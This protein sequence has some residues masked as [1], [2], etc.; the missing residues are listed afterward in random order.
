MILSTLGDAVAAGNAVLKCTNALRT[1]HHYCSTWAKAAGRYSQTKRDE[2]VVE[3]LH[4]IQVAD[5]YRWLEDPDSEESK[6]CALLP[7][8]TPARPSHA[9]IH[10]LATIGL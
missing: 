5:P 4:G 10:T 3:E 9:A 1:S 2:S 8:W 6:A 7:N